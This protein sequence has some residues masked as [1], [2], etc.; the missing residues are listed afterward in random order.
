MV[1]GNIDA[2]RDWGY[3]PEYV[4]GMWKILQHDKA[5]DFVLATGK[6]NSVREFVELTFSELGIKINWFGERENERGKDK[7]S[8]KTLIYI[9][10]KYYRP[11][12]V[13]ILLGNPEKAK[14][15]LGWQAST[16]LK[17][18]VKIMVEAEVN[19]LSQ[20]KFR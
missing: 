4:G 18:L 1:L 8:G 14:E 17:D 12:E 10:P 11:T 5:D 15:K 20:S 19:S 6:S 16:S 9:D 2:K 7:D 13:D 3:A